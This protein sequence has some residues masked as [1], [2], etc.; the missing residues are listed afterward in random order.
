VI[1]L[2][3]FHCIKVRGRRDFIDSYTVDAKYEMAKVLNIISTVKLTHE[4][5]LCVT[6]RPGNKKINQILFYV[7]LVVVKFTNILFTRFQ[8]ASAS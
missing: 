4:P 5:Q 6:F 8:I 1:T 3:G 7:H 2:S